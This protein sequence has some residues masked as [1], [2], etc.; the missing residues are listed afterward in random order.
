MCSSLQQRL[1]YLV[2][3][4]IKDPFTH[5][6]IIGGL[7][8]ALYQLFGNKNDGYNNQ[9]IISELEINNTI[10]NWQNRW[11]R[12]PSEAELQT[13]L[14][15]QVR[16]EVFYR[17]A[18]ALDLGKDDP[19][20]RR[21]LAEKMMFIAN[22]LLVPEQASDSQLIDFMKAFPEKFSKPIVTTFK[23]IYFN[24]DLHDSKLS[25]QIKNYQVALNDKDRQVEAQKLGDDFNGEFEYQ[26]LP[27]HQT[28]RF[29]GQQFTAQL[30]QLPIGRWEGPINSGYGQHLVNIQTRSKAELIPLQ[31]VRDKVLIEWRAE[32]Q[33]RSN[34]AL[35]AKLRDNYEVVLERADI[36][37]QGQ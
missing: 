27:D 18:L 28:A 12:L 31:Q 23:Q 25:Q 33:K 34:D 16:Q 37:V 15:Q 21:R 29:F 22:D 36:T 9:I 3:K 11:Q 4:L 14:E 24:P 19:V 17:E 26:H 6:L 1:D 35:Y 2:E 7:L 10:N 8:F 5:F 20:V 13:V 30:S 32:Q